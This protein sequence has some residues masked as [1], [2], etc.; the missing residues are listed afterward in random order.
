MM[1]CR[2]DPFWTEPPLALQTFICDA[3][4]MT[5]LFAALH[6]GAE[7]HAYHRPRCKKPSNLPSSKRAKVKA[8]RQANCRRIRARR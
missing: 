4:T 2:S 5:E 6:G 8:A 3:N 7:R 1:T